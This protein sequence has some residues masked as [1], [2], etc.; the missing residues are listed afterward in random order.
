LVVASKG[1]GLEVNVDKAKYMVMSRDKHAGRS[2]NIKIDNS[3]FERV[4][5]FR[6]LGTN[7]INQ[8][9]IQEE[10]ESRL[11]SGNA[12][13]HSVQNL[14]SFSLLSKNIKIKVYRTIILRVVWYWCESW[15]ST[16]REERRLTV[17]RIFGPKRGEVT[18]WR[19]LQNEGLSDPYCSP[20][21]V[22]MI[23]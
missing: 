16:L 8:N 3:S 1:I 18:D 6:Y 7:L 9:S 10:N 5:E 2:Q 15:S 23:K 12:Y 21:S 19:K 11:N 4:E 13:Y 17:L 22:R 20:N 14:L